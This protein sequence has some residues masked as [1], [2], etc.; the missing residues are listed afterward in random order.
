MTPTE[1]EKPNNNGGRNLAIFGVVAIILGVASSFLSLYIYNVTGDVYLDRSRPGFISE[2]EPDEPGSSTDQ[3]TAFSPD[4]TITE[5]DIDEYLKKLDQV[6]KD[7][8]PESG[9]FSADA[10]S[11][12]SLNITGSAE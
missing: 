2:D 4:G 3:E 10:L 6:I 9:A 8:T 7:V 5:Q 11:D 1:K 12:E